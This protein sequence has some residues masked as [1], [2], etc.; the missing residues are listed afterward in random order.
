MDSKAKFKGLLARIFS[1]AEVDEAERAELLEFLASGALTV[2]ERSEVVASF[3][4]TTW[5]TASADGRLSENETKRLR[6]I[7]STL[8]LVKSDLPSGWADV[9]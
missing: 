8:A 1:N 3:V 4:S 6:A 2:D 9:L 7:A 5:K